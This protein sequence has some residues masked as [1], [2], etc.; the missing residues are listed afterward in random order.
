MFQKKL[1]Y[2]AKHPYYH[3]LKLLCKNKICC[4]KIRNALF[5]NTENVSI[6]NT[7]KRLFQIQ[8]S[9][10]LKYENPAFSKKRSVAFLNLEYASFSNNRIPQYC[11]NSFG[12]EK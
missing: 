9:V 11:T 5:S 8:K 1:R 12:T 2:I 3:F 4:F 6:S 10:H 7:G